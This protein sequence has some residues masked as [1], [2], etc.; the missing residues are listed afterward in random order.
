MAALTNNEALLGWALTALD[1]EHSP[2]PQLEVVAGDAS[3][4]SYYRFA[5]GQQNYIVALAPPATEKNAAF[6]AV[7][8]VLDEAGVRVPQ[9]YAVDLE[10]GYLLLE[11]LGDQLL[12]DLLHADSVDGYY[13]R[14][15]GVLL[16]MAAVDCQTCELGEYDRELLTEELQR[17]DTWFVRGLLGYTPTNA[18]QHMV[19]A[20]F[21][22]LIASAL[23]QPQV[24]VHRDFHSRNIMLTEADELGIID[25]QDAVAGPVSYDAVSL[26]RD[27]Y[28]QWPAAQVAAWCDAYYQQLCH[29]GLL[30]RVPAE[31]FRQWFDWMGLQRHIKVLGTFARL[32][33]RDNKPGYLEDLPV[34]LDYV[35]EMLEHYAADAPEIAAFRDWFA[36][37]LTPLVAARIAAQLAAQRAAR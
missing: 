31:Q 12:L 28:V 23:E 8:N 10:H 3:S 14:A 7:R 16:Q 35:H 36:T 20:F 15:F 25:Y 37:R 11:D 24:L 34:V 21:A 26:L 30:T 2:R 13:Q 17:F 32:S 6:I 4:R 5:V 33:L 27:C 18:E 19:D 29:A 22:V 9:I 1:R